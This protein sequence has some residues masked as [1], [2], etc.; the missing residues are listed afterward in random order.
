MPL[1]A[2]AKPLIVVA[3]R[4]NTS[5][6]CFTFSLFSRRTTPVDKPAAVETASA[7]T[8]CVLEG[9]ERAPLFWQP[10]HNG[11]FSPRGIANSLSADS[12]ALLARLS[13]YRCL[14][15]YSKLI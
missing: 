10:G 3:L 4:T 8:E 11:F 2:N 7:L 14:P 1:S 9:P 5:T 6:V 15:S 13:L 12:P